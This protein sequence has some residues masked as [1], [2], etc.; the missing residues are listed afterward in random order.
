MFS[1]DGSGEVN[2]LDF[3]R[4][5]LSCAVAALLAGCGVVRQAQ[6]D[7]PPIGVP[8]AMPQTSATATRTTSTSYKVVNSFGGGSDG[9]NPDAGLIDVKGT[10]YCT[11]FAGGSYPCTFYSS[12]W[13][14]F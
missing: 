5:A 9:A 13:N 6:S 8:G 3:S 12:G 11:T 10:L 1:D 2:N 14:A 7:M 4:H